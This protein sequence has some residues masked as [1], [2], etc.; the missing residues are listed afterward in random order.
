[1]TVGVESN[2]LLQV[3]RLPRKVPRHPRWQGTRVHLVWRRAR[4][5]RPGGAWRASP[6]SL[7]PCGSQLAFRGKVRTAK[8]SQLASAPLRGSVRTLR[9]APAASLRRSAP[10]TCLL[11][12]AWFPAHPVLRRA[13]RAGLVRDPTLPQSHSARQEQSSG[14]RVGWCVAAPRVG[15]F[16]GW[17]GSTV[18]LS[19]FPA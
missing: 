2:A 18:E 1:M 12:L 10:G 16:G 5:R 3:S 19:H 17:R 14:V 4:A 15:R 7:H 13:Q 11:A 6:L 8:L 9:A